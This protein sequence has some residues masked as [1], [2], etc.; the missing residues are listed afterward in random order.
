MIRGTWLE[1]E[2][3][4]LGTSQ[5][6][7]F[8]ALPPA[9]AESLPPPTAEPLP[10]QAIIPDTVRRLVYAFHDPA[11]AA[12]M[13]RLPGLI[14]CEL[15]MWQMTM[16]RQQASGEA[17]LLTWL[18]PEIQ[19]P[20]GSAVE[21]PLS[22]QDGDP[23]SVVRCRHHLRLPMRWTL[24]MTS[25]LLTWELSCDWTSTWTMCRSWPRFGLRYY[26]GVNWFPDWDSRQR[27]QLPVAIELR[28]QLTSELPPAPPIGAEVAGEFGD[29]LAA[30]ASALNLTSPPPIEPMDDR[31]RSAQTRPPEDHRVV[32]FLRHRRSEARTEAS[33]FQKMR[34]ARP[35]PTNRSELDVPTDTDRT[36]AS[37]AP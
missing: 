19:G 5:A 3:F 37:I 21:S 18:R 4:L 2:S 14:R 27:G 24:C 34:W 20:Q 31:L 26:D 32:I 35:G 10:D 25:R 12:R 1:P 11:T 9:A 23:Q 22:N 8:D 33:I 6:L 30:D 15:T 36:P 29:E 16:L 7:M 13:D 28:F 17:D